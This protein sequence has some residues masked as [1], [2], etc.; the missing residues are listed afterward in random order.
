[1]REKKP[2]LQILFLNKTSKVSNVF[3]FSFF[4]SSNFVIM[5]LQDHLVGDYRQIINMSN[6]PINLIITYLSSVKRN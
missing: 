2:L 3:F 1:M 6:S 5:V 4:T